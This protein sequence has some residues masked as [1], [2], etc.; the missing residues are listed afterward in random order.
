MPHLK[1]TSDHFTALDAGCKAVLSAHPGLASQYQ[2]AELSSIR[3][4]W[5]VLRAATIQGVSGTAWICANLYS[6]L[7]DNHIDSALRAIMPERRR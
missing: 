5:D 7:N 6:Y 1:I 2:M 3:M 4:R